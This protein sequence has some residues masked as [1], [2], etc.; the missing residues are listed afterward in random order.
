[1]TFGEIFAASF[2]LLFAFAVGYYFGNNHAWNDATKIMDS[3]KR[4]VDKDTR[5]G[6]RR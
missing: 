4:V 1:M 6:G 3:S 2:V 5:M